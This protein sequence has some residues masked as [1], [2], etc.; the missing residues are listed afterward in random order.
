[1][2]KP[3]LNVAKNPVNIDCR[4]EGIKALLNLGT[5][6]D[7]RIVGIYGMGGIGKTTLAKVV[8]NQIYNGFEGSSCLL[9]IKQTEHRY[10]LVH[11]QEKLLFNVLKTKNLKISN[12]DRGINL[13]KERFRC[14]RVLVIL[15][16]A[17]YLKQFNSLAGSSEWF[18][19]RS[20]VIL[21]TR[22]EH[23]LTKLGVHEKYMVKELT[24]S[25]SLQLFSWHAFSMAHLK[26]D[27]LELSVSVVN[28]ARGL[29][30]VL[31]ILGSSLLGRNTIE[32]E[33]ALK[34]LQ[35]F[36]N[37]EIQKILEMS[38][39][40]LDDDTVK[41][42]FFDIA[43]F[44][45]GMDK[46]Y[47]IKIFDGCGFFPYI[48]INILIERS[49]VTIN[50]NNELRMHDLIRDMGREVVRQMSPNDLGKRSR[51]WIHKE[52]LNVLDNHLVRGRCF[53]I[54]IYI[55]IYMYMHID[56]ICIYYESLSIREF[57][58][59]AKHGYS[60]NILSI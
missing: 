28:Y 10:G 24:P 55:Y 48:G 23:V 35:N 22:D 39:Y 37:R 29:P 31:E 32:W 41:D 15:D 43:C 52:V 11:L 26:E 51:L 40:S 14:K 12:V 6:S 56:I 60:L 8:Y 5:R 53:N 42:T 20:R 45:V 25:E 59:F 3:C 18:G 2:N 4:V 57:C 54:Y 27:F 21:T 30:L 33:D 50:D 58:L 16:D 19:P 46:D 7:V 38:F 36:P 9:D 13:I 17:D 47:A 49:L 1:V 34:K 44:F